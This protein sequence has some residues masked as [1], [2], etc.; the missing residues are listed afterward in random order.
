M[1][2]TTVNQCNIQLSPTRDEG[3]LWNYFQSGMSR[4][5]CRE[6]SLALI[7]QLAPNSA[8]SWAKELARDD[9]EGKLS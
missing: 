6:Q 2:Q 5:L 7:C 3:S 1:S 8:H 9:T 4:G